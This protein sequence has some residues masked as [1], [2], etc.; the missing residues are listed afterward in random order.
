MKLLYKAIYSP[1]HTIGSTSFLIDDQYFL[2]GDILFID[3]F[4][5]PDLAEKAEDWV[6]VLFTI[7]IRT[8][9]ENLPPQPNA[10]Q[11]YAKRTWVK[12]NLIWMFFMC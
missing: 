10:Y 2:T 3:L 11:E 4:G 7:D 9:T 6:G 5:R 1:G 12:S 8:V